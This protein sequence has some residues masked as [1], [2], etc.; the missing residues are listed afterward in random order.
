M[1]LRYLSII[2]NLLRSI[3]SDL[4][5]YLEN[6]DI[7]YQLF[8]MRWS[9]LLLSREFKSIDKHVLPI[10]DY[11]F[12]SCSRNIRNPTQN[13]I[14]RLSLSHAAPET[15][16]PKFSEKNDPVN[17]S[18]L[19]VS[20][21]LDSKKNDDVSADVFSPSKVMHKKR[22][23]VPPVDPSRLKLLES[24]QTRKAVVDA[25]IFDSENTLYKQK[26]GDMNA[27][28]LVSNTPYR[29]ENLKH[30]NIL[31]PLQFIMAAMLITVFS[32][33]FIFFVLNSF[34]DST[35]FVGCRQ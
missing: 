2:E 14:N 3:D 6:L 32:T 4:C 31:S 15:A 33:C 35:R 22:H 19:E 10:W 12:Y 18:S 23:S 20:E 5:D 8:G 28:I 34:L 9:R 7:P 27:T 21:F 17:H 26:D 16:N 30:Q 24:I 25:P 1:S 11:I 29:Y 13:E